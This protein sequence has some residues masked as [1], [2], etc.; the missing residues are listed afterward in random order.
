MKLLL[1]ANKLIYNG[2]STYALNLAKGLKEAGFDL[3]FCLT[4]GNRRPDLDSLGIENYLIKFN[5]FSFRK[6]ISF[7][8]EFNPDLVHITS[9]DAVPPGRKIARRLKKQF[10]ITIH[11]LLDIK[12]KHLPL[13]QSIGIIVANEN[14]REMLVNHLNIPKERLRMIPKGVDLETFDHPVR[15]L[16]DRLPVIGCIGRFS[17]GKG[18]AYFIKAARKVLDTGR[19]AVFLLLGEGRNETHLRRLIRDLQLSKHITISPPLEKNSEIYRIID[20]LVLPVTKA[21]STQTAIEAMASR[22]P[23]IASVVGDLLHLIK[24]EENG[25]ATKPKHIE[26]LAQAMCRLI[27]DPQFAHTLGEQARTFVA[28]HFPEKRMI[29]DTITLYNDILKGDFPRK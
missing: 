12:E 2:R 5:Y 29:D 6:L 15:E 23:V 8:S 27:D 14:M 22:R 9:E 28:A 25:L 1:L 3:L 13:S 16:G 20:I 11:D 26:D 19:N 18:Q 4:G 7:A 10:L 21:A 17:E 24:H